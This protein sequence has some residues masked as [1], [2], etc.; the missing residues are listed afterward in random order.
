MSRLFVLCFIQFMSIR[1]AFAR[2]AVSKI[3]VDNRTRQNKNTG[4]VMIILSNSVKS[5]DV[6]CR[7]V[8]KNTL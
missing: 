7:F 5:P 6:F 3:E 2:S 8:G 4:H 1:D